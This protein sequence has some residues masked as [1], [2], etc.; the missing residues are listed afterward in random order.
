M[1]PHPCSVRPVL[2]GASRL[3]SGVM[4]AGSEFVFA[5][6]PSGL[7]LLL[8]VVPLVAPLPGSGAAGCRKGFRVLTY[9]F[10]LRTTARVAPLVVSLAW[11]WCPGLLRGASCS[12]PA[13]R[14]RQC[15]SAKWPSMCYLIPALFAQCDW[16]RLSSGLVSRWPRGL[17]CSHF[18][19][20]ALVS[21]V[22]CPARG[23]SVLLS[24]DG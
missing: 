13:P 19:P 3:G 5:H 16:L 15:S 11:L 17:S 6:L 24:C 1:L 14:T 22:R 9:V 23:A 18:F 12:H 10:G 4:V 20:R 8:Y 21:S 2:L 7:N